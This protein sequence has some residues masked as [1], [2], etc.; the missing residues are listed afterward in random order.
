MKIYTK[1]GDKGHTDLF[2][3][4]R[5]AKSDNRVMAYGSV[6]S[7][8]ATI[9]FVAACDQLSDEHRSQL[10]IIMSDLF[11]MGAELAT[12]QKK[13]AQELLKK[14]LDSGVTAVRVGELETFIDRLEKNLPELKSFVLPT[15]VEVAARFHLARVAVREAEQKVVLLIESGFALRDEVVMYLNRLSDLMFVFSRFY[16][17]KQGKGD[18]L[19]IARAPKSL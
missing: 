6:D 11:D 17:F 4:V 5:V 8:N 19:W 1:G 10:Y 16:N 2:G 7:A 3:G 9:G 18:V 12:A 15:G 14:R 13:S